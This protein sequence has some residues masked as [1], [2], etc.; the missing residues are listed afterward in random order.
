MQIQS[1]SQKV[2]ILYQPTVEK[3]QL[4]ADQKLLSVTQHLNPIPNNLYALSIH[5]NKCMSTSGQEAVVSIDRVLNHLT[6]YN[7]M[8]IETGLAFRKFG[9]TI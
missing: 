9:H 4:Y 1:Q 8:L 5:A 2:I 6:N 3:N 7:R